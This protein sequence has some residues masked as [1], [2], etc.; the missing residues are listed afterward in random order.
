MRGNFIRSSYRSTKADTDGDGICDGPIA[1]KEFAILDRDG[2]GV[3][4]EFDDFPDDPSASK[5]T[6]GMECQTQ[7]QAIQLQ[8][9]YLKI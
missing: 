1:L 4:N 6:D 8:I 3:N 9:Q 2:D 5:D 7:S